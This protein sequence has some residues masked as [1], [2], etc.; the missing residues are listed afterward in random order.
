MD[1]VSSR[2]ADLLCVSSDLSCILQNID[3]FL[4]CLSLKSGGK[5]IGAVC[6]I[7]GALFTVACIAS[8]AIPTIQV[9][10]PIYY[11]SETAARIYGIIIG[12]LYVFAALELIEGC[13][14]V[15]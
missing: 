11:Y 1:S 8:F 14:E 6:C 10:K 3:T 12:C 7:G 9:C 5:I 2:N 13:E 4:G 15:S